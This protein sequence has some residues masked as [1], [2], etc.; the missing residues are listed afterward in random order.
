MV[1]SSWFMVRR[2]FPFLFLVSFALFILPSSALADNPGP[3]GVL[4]LQELIRRIINISVGLAFM[5][6]AVMLVVAGIKYLVSGGES[7]MLGSA[8]GTVTWALLGVL[9]LALAWIILLLI[10]ALTGVDVLNFCIGFPG[11]TPACK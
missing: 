3:A 9:F 7:K 2:L 4:Q 1:H 10:Q 6:V 8:A 5:I 11:V